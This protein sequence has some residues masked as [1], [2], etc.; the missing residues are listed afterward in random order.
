MVRFAAL[1][2][3]VVCAGVSGFQLA[4]ALGAPWGELTLGGRWKGRLP[5]VVRLIPLIS[6]ATLG[7]FSIVILAR[8]GYDVPLIQGSFRALTWV[9]V[10]YCAL[11]C[12]ANAITPSARERRLWLPVVLGMLLLSVAVAVS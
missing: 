2:F 9:V 10:G 6:V 4:L 12:I 7:V 1:L 3:V 5:P 11:G 8:A